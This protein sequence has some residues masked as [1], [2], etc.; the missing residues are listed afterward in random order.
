MDFAQQTTCKIYNIHRKEGQREG[1]TGF[2][3]TVE[4]DP[5]VLH[6]MKCKRGGRRVAACV[7]GERGP[8]GGAGRKLGAGGGGADGGMG[9]G[10]G[11]TDVGSGMGS[12]G[13]GQKGCVGRSG[14]LPEWGQSSAN[15]K[16]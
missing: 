1:S 8:C 11:G 9:C 14:A 10:D 6:T 3:D 12:E 5:K 2:S 7:Q 15:G 4:R 13:G 16:H